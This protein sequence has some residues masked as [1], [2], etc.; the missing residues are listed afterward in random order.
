M[1]EL[2][3]PI[4]REAYDEDFDRNQ[5][6]RYDFSDGTTVYELKQYMLHRG[7]TAVSPTG[8]G[9]H[10]PTNEQPLVRSL[11]HTLFSAAAL[12]LLYVGSIPEGV[13]LNTL[14]K[15]DD[16]HEYVRT[17]HDL[18]REDFLHED[19]LAGSAYE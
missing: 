16:F 17:T 12:E 4:R 11:M 3:T 15:D 13:Q 6:N 9:E 14:F 10:P 1:N 5:V 18:M 8:Q 19:H 7:Y 2:I